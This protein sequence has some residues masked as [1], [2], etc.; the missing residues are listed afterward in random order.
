[1]GSSSFGVCGRCAP[2]VDLDWGLRDYIRAYMCLLHVTLAGKTA[3]EALGRWGKKVEM[4]YIQELH[5]DKEQMEDYWKPQRQSKHGPGLRFSSNQIGFKKLSFTKM[6]EAEIWS[7]GFVAE[8][9]G[10]CLMLSR[11]V[12]SAVGSARPIPPCW[13]NSTHCDTMHIYAWAKSV[14]I[15]PRNCTWRGKK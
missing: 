5:W 11:T 4:W 15:A 10:P 3:E 9:S 13:M 6:C 8:D 2:A 12:Q 1:M 7:N 14:S